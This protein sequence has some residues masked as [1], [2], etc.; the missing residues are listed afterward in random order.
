MADPGK[1]CPQSAPDG[2]SEDS[3]SKHFLEVCY[4]FLDYGNEARKEI[5]FLQQNLAR[6]SPE[7]KALWRVDPTQFFWALEAGVN[8]NANFLSQL[9]EGDVCSSPI[10]P[11]VLQSMPPGHVVE[12][13][14][15]SKARS[16]LRQFVRDWAVEGLQERE[17]S[18]GPLIEAVRKYLP[19]GGPHT[20]RILCPG[21][22]LA[23]LPFELATMGYAAQ[24]NEFSYHMILGSRLIFDGSTEAGSYVIFPYVLN[25]SGRRRFADN[26]V[27]I[28]I[29]DI[30]PCDVMPPGS[31]FSM[32]AGEFVEVYGK[33]VQEWDGLA[34]CF[35]LDTAKNVFQYVRVMASILRSGGIWTNLGPLLFHYAENP[36]DIS[37]ELSWEE[38][39]PVI[40]K[41]FDFAEET[42]RDAAYTVGSQSMTRRVYHCLFFV[43]IRNDVPISGVSRPVF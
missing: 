31:D 35:F 14:N 21:C 17:V 8:T 20:P 39:R 41:Y 9:P 25:T 34:T 12:G 33:Q 18:Y 11:D 6:L 3:E 24:G 15:A 22:G 43:A 40:A 38:L 27:P 30:S 32:A 28:K 29:P 7:D 42:R 26:A 23:R 4:S 2:N 13:R 1:R 16:T 37:I 19:L 36:E 5:E 10:H